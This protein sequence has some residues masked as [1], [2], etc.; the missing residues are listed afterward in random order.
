MGI[1]PQDAPQFIA[2]IADNNQL[3]MYF[4]GIVTDT[5]K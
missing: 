4:T 2:I 5:N 3:I 1:P